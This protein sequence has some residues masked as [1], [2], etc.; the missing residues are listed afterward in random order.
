MLVA[1]LDGKPVDAVGALR[2]LDYRCPNP[3]CGSALVV[4]QGAKVIHH[5]AH[6]PPITC[7]W[8]A[9]ETKDHREAKRILL[10]SLKN[11]SVRA[12]AEFVV[13]T[14]PGDRRADIMAWHPRT[15]QMIAFELQHS[16]VSVDEIQRRAFSYARAGIAQIWIP[17]LK[18]KYMERAEHEGCE[19]LIERYPPRPFERWI[20]ELHKQ[21][22]MWMYYPAAK[23]LWLGWL[24]PS[25]LYK[26]E[27]TWYG[28]GG[29]EMV[30]GGYLYDSKRYCDLS[31]YGPFDLS[32]LL[33]RLVR[34]SS[35]RNSNGR[36]PEGKI[37]TFQRCSLP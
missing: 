29:E 16:A 19:A 20:S 28:E 25:A 8:E 32:E 2:G 13:D 12:Q 3:E 18:K 15:D 27:S 37:A 23:S 36:W 6:K 33:I 9:S 35:Y 26:E 1:S 7:A 4:K 10:D 21:T 17:F 30:S 31:L 24:K 14:L 22:G 5:F 11:R 34:R